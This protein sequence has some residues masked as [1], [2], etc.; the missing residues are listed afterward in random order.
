MAKNKQHFVPQFYLRAFASKPKLIHLY[1]F[2]L[3]KAIPDVPLRLQC[4]KHRFYGE[5]DDLENILMVADDASSE[6]LRQIIHDSIL[7]LQGGQEH[8]ALLSF[9]TLQLLRTPTEANKLR[10]TID[11]MREQLLKNDPTIKESDLNQLGPSSDRPVEITLSSFEKMLWSITDL[12]THL[13]CA[14]GDHQ[15]ITSD[16]PVIRYNQHYESMNQFGMRGGNCRGLQIFLPISPKHLL[17]L[18]DSS[19]YQMSS[20]KT[21]VT[22]NVSDADIDILN[23]LQIVGANENLYFNEWNSS[24]QIQLLVQRASTYRAYDPVD[25]KQLYELGKEKRSSV[26]LARQNFPNLRLS[27]SFVRIFKN[28][29]KLSVKDRLAPSYRYRRIDPGT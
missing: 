7:P 29:L 10:L 3:G 5:T 13:V 6:I 16:A 24:N 26:L 15:F 19:I 1:N 4:Y 12:K 25:V 18:Y 28:A 17:I 2:A 23:V 21:S 20:G 14:T 9:V 8:I 27:L 22:H 11:K